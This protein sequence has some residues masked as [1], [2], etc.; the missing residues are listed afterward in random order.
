MAN[1]SGESHRTRQKGLR[2]FGEIGAA[3][4]I[5]HETARKDYERAI[6]KIRRRL[7]ILPGQD[8]SL[9]EE[10][11]R[12]LLLMLDQKDRGIEYSLTADIVQW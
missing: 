9:Q 8:G 2:T 6:K 12:E 4:G 7:G 3:L 1:H 10:E 5:N 11:I